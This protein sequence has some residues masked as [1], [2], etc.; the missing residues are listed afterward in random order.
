VAALFLTT[1]RYPVLVPVTAT[2]ILIAQ[3]GG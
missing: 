1:V 2:V 3:V